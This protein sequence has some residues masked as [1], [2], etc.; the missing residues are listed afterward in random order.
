MVCST[1]SLR[2]T[3][4]DYLIK[5]EKAVPGLVFISR[6]KQKILN[7]LSLAIQRK[8]MIGDLKCN[9]STCATLRGVKIILNDFF[10]LL[11]KPQD[12]NV[13]LKK[14]KDEMEIIHSSY[15]HKIE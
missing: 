6:R 12:K 9:I 15:S 13:F 4:N 14:R 2:N 5:V 7:V 11:F 1:L 10:L 8:M 3:K